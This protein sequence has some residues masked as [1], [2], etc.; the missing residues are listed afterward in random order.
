[1]RQKH[2]HLHD[3]SLHINGRQLIKTNNSQK[4]KKS[5]MERFAQITDSIVT[6]RSLNLCRQF[7]DEK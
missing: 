2:Y 3:Q 4:K 5:I 7:V 6:L 1:M